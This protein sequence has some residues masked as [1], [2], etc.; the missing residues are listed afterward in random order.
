MLPSATPTCRRWW[1]VRFLPLAISAAT[2]HHA[3]YSSDKREAYVVA[4]RRDIMLYLEYKSVCAL[5]RI[6]FAHPLSRMRVC[7]PP[8][9]HGGGGATLA[10]G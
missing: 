8:R 9:N 10:C 3:S 2:V 4:D 7:P 1:E 5:V 6:G